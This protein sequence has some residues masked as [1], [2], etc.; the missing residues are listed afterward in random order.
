MKTNNF[1]VLY[2]IAILV[3]ILLNS[4]KKD[5]PGSPLNTSSSAVT[6]FETT[7]DQTKLL[8]QQPTIKFAPDSSSNANNTITVDEGTTYQTIDGF[9]FALTDASAIVIDG[10]SAGQQTALLQELFAPTGDGISS[11]YLR[12]GIGAEALSLSDYT[13]DDLSSGTDDNLTSFSLSPS[14]PDLIPVLKKIV[15]INPNI[16]ILASPFSP[17]AWMKTNNKLVG[18]TLKTSSYPI[19]ANYLVKYIQAMQAQGIPID[20]ITPQNEP[21]DS[22][23]D[24]SMRFKADEEANFIKNNLGPAFK[25]AGLK[26]K[27]ICYDHNCDD[28]DYPRAVLSDTGAFAYTD[29]SAFHFYAGLI[30]ALSV[31]HNAYPTKNIYFTEQYTSSNGTFAGYLESQTSNLIMGATRNWSR[32]VI[33]WTLAGDANNGPHKPDGCQDCLPAIT[34]SSTIKRNIQYYVFAHASK[35]VH[36]GAVRISSNITGDIQNVAFKNTDNSKVII[37]LNSGT[38]TENFKVKWGTESFSYSLPAGAVATFK[39]QG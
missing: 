24:P 12:I 4:C 19:Y 11:S 7:A 35:F 34:I 31:V 26:T 10:L 28:P 32:N 3:P 14:M 16:K 30:T 39:W 15:A 22:T 23:E 25:S 17:P 13:Y 6:I 9:G 21:R 1:S 36:P 2:S 27:I 20:A 18:G 29:G 37:V 8:E 38:I 5:H 33:G